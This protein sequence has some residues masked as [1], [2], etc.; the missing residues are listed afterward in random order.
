MDILIGFAVAA[1]KAGVSGVVGNEIVQALVDQGSDIGL[2]KLSQYLEKA[3]K[4]LSQV[5]SDKSLMKMNV[6][7]DYIDYIK[8][9]IKGLLRSISIDED[10]F[11][12][13]H[14]DAKSLAEA[15]YIKYKRQKKDFVECESEI[16]KVLYVMSEKAISLEKERDGFIADILTDIINN[17]EEQMELIKKILRTLDES[18]KTG[19][20]DSENGGGSQK[21]KR[22]RDQT[23]EY[24][25]KWDENMSLNEF[26]EGDDNLGVDIS[27]YKFTFDLE[28]D[29]L[30]GIVS[31]LT[32]NK[33][34]E[35]YFNSR[36]KNFTVCI[37][38]KRQM[39]LQENMKK[40]NLKIH[41]QKDLTLEEE[42][43]YELY[44]RALQKCNRESLLKQKAIEFFLKDQYLQAF[45]C[46][47]NYLQLLEF[48][49]EIL[50]YDYFNQDRYNNKQNVMLDIYLTP[51]PKEC[52]DH[53][54]V[55]IEK[56]KLDELFGGHSVYDIF[57][58]DLIDFDKKT[59][60]EIAVA[61][62]MFLAEEVICFKNE[63][64]IENKKVLNLLEYR[65]GVH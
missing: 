33:L 15:I 45:F 52:N 24:R 59:R 61:F 2:D 31:I 40:L 11:R 12:N 57:G 63:N 16:Q 5:L 53:F 21:E 39:K 9:E 23:K 22:L 44:T 6:P 54:I 47:N 13:C 35:W 64:I 58:A 38:D 49:K 1:L 55:C 42:Y 20:M 18:M 51:E 46:M 25:R 50:N 37:N 7:E 27:V 10:L 43:E 8:E 29:N 62:Y 65:V 56:K 48:V 32:K 34:R 60:R 28:I 14:Y 4:E 26:N 30:S 3:Q 17:Q 36:Y 41:D 19:I